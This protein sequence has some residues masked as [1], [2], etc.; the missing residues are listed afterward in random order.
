MNSAYRSGRW[1]DESTAAANFDHGDEPPIQTP[2]AVAMRRKNL[3]GDMCVCIIY[4][5]Y[6]QLIGNSVARPHGRAE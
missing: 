1:G 2:A 5:I 6:Y 3:H 4:Y